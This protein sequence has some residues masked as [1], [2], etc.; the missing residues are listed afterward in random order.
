MVA[1]IT[2]MRT[3]FFHISP[4]LN[5]P[6]NPFLPRHARKKE[7]QWIDSSLLKSS[8]LIFSNPATSRSG[9]WS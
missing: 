1:N 3:I 7:D 2:R 8:K 4:V 9:S 5:S 6:F